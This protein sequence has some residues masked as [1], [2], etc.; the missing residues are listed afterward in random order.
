VRVFDRQDCSRFVGSVPVDCR[1]SWGVQ[2][3]YP[4]K[5]LVDAVSTQ[6]VREIGRKWAQKTAKTPEFE[7]IITPG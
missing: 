2:A 7:L 4:R 5:S 1:A 6:G 3:V